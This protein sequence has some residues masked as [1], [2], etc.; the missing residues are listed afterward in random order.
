[1]LMLRI[2]SK[3]KRLIFKRL[4]LFLQILEFGWPE[5]LAPSLERLCS[6]CK[7][8][9]QW[10]NADPKN[11][12]VLHCKGG[13]GRMGVSL[14]AYI[15]YCSICARQVISSSYSV[16]PVYPQNIGFVYL[17]FFCRLQCS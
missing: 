9:D 13:L 5:T 1:M 11:V 6:I 16:F 4:T 17:M 7:L 3:N 10:L 15:D 2:N 12:L 8:I 14:S